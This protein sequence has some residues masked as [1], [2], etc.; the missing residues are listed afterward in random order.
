[1]PEKSL[2]E[3]NADLNEAYAKLPKAAKVLIFLFT[4]VIAI[5]GIVAF[6]YG[7]ICSAFGIDDNQGEA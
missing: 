7:M 2:K 4:P 5:L 6:F 1:M 3:R